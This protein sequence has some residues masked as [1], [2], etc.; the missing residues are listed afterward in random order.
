MENI[1]KLGV[2]VVYF[3]YGIKVTDSQNGFRGLSKKAA[4]KIKLTCDRM[5]HAGEFFWEITKN[6]L[7]YKFS[8]IKSFYQY[9]PKISFYKKMIDCP[10]RSISRSNT[11]RLY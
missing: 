2:L 9:D 3:L 10:T 11:V 6:K 5:D 4:K 8:T 7:K 1:L